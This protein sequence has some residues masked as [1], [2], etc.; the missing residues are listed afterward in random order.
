MLR[1][2]VIVLLIAL[3]PSPLRAEARIA[4][5]ITNQA[6][7]Q[8]G[9]RLTNTYHDGEVIKAALEKVGF[10]VWTVRD[11]TSERSL[12]QAVAEHVQRLA[13]AGPDAVGFLYYS[14]HGAA[15]RPNGEN[16]LIP[17][18]VPL[19]HASQLPL[20]AVRL[21]KI[22]SALA[23]AGKMSF[24][25]F[26]ACR[27]V[28]LLRETK[29]LTFKGFAPVREQ[30]GLL[31]AFATEPGNVAVD[32]SLYA[33]AL[34]DAMVAPGL[35]A[36]QVFRRVRLR[37]R[38]DTGQA[39]SPEYLDKRDRD[40]SF[41]EAA[42][43]PTAPPATATD[44][45]QTSKAVEAWAVTKDTTSIA[46]VE[47][48]IDRYKDTYYAGLARL[49]IEELKKKI[50]MATPPS[51]PPPARPAARCDGVETQVGSEHRC[52]KLKDTFRDCPDCPEMVVVP[53]GSFMMGAPASEKGRNNSEV[54]EHEVTVGQPFAVGRFAVTRGEFA[55]F[56]N[57]TKHKT[58]GGCHTWSAGWTQQSDKSWHS[59]SFNQD[60]QHPVVCVS[61]DDAKAFATWLS[62]KAGK[63]Y[64]LLSEAERE[65]VTRAGTS[66]PFWW[67]SDISAT[68]ANYGYG[69]GHTVPVNSFE[70]NPWGLYNVHGNVWDWT[71]DCWH[72]NYQGV[73]NMGAPTN[74]SA[75]TT[76]CSEGRSTVR[77]GSWI[78]VPP[79]LLRSAYRT[80]RL[81]DR[82]YND[83]GFRL[84]RTL[85]P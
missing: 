42:F 58:D 48:F 26:D 50:A 7:T 59:P 75:W 33:K 80:W 4:L 55:T 40:F 8:A 72:T 83:L 49:R 65:Y 2:A 29:D 77:G 79:E 28:P 47:L 54:P 20:L 32:Q 69:G 68:Q 19:T 41:V 60:D 45:R 67:G 85:N 21:E 18:D 23:S 10:K 12:L 5:V 37:V 35:E 63:P 36:G 15:D 6:Y 64:R 14:G 16:F 22:T 25:V 44:H 76:A 34:A 66:T 73:N 43:S 57:A 11:T 39:Q 52:L 17:T 70:A 71:E 9:A 3:L 24:V 27:N 81:A 13:E 51:S 31:V 74:G 84:A 82:R 30:N 62:K 1:A 38:V 78:I 56:V 61:R 53:A 46:A